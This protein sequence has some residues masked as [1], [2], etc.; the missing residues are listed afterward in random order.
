M[1]SEP[2]RGRRTA[3]RRGG[4]PACVRGTATGVEEASAPQTLGPEDPRPPGHSH[5]AWHHGQAPLPPALGSLLSLRL[6]PCDPQPTASSG[7]GRTESRGT[8]GPRLPWGPPAPGA[9]ILRG[10]PVPR[11]GRCRASTAKSQ[12]QR[13]RCG[14]RVATVP[15]AAAPRSAW[16]RKGGALAGGG[17]IHEA[18]LLVLVASKKWSLND[19]GAHLSSFWTRLAVK[20]SLVGNFNHK[21]DSG[22]RPPLRES[23]LGQGE[24]QAVGSASVSSLRTQWTFTE[25]PL[26]AKLGTEDAARRQEMRTPPWGQ[27][28]SANMTCQRV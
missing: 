16:Q 14:A 26:H 7:Q 17:G 4:G 23:R 5:P 1:P 22:W 21:P 2:F 28:P 20:L 6:A 25:R 3:L 10:C 18:S 13:Q 11:P 27:R 19:S 8:R 15:A 12:V 24:A 9:S